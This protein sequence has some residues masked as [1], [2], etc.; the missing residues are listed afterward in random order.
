V[1]ARWQAP[2]V[3]AAMLLFWGAVLAV[4]SS[5]LLQASPLLLAGLGGLAV[6][7]CSRRGHVVP[8]RRPAAAG[9]AAV[10]LTVALLGMVA[11]PWLAL[12]GGAVVVVAIA[13]GLRP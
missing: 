2:A 1:T 10:G 13:M 4:W 11:G 6:A 9:L 7:L 3:W 8:V 5:S 12:I